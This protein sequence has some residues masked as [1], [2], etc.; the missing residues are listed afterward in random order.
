MEQ[1]ESLNTLA[2]ANGTKPPSNTYLGIANE[3]RNER[4]P[5][6]LIERDEIEGTPFQVV[7]VS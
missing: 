1:Q 2:N 5:D 7:G 3:D 6:Q 4:K